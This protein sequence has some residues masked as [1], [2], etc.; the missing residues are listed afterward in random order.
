MKNS[1]LSLYYLSNTLT[2]LADLKKDKVLG[3]LCKLL[4]IFA[5]KDFKERIYPEA[6]KYYSQM[7][8]EL[9]NSDKSASLPNYL[10]DFCANL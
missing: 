1:F 7:C 9:Y 4:E 10:Y 5:K 3:N 6:T 8:L 2:V